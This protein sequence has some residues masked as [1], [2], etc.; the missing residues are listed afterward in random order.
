MGSPSVWGGELMSDR[1]GFMLYFDIE[2]ALTM[3]KDSQRGQLFTAIMNYA[4]YADVP[5]FEDKLIGMAWSLIRPSLDR[6]RRSYEKKVFDNRIKGLKSDFRRNYAPKHGIDPDDEVEME[7]Y[8]CQRMSTEVDIRQRTE[9]PILA[10]IEAI[11]LSPKTTGEGTRT[12]VQG[13]VENSTAYGYGAG[14]DFD[15]LRNQKMRQLADYAL[16]DV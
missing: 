3:L 16:N 2:P 15:N 1:P 5:D 6:D 12:G 13:E 10:Q 4:H 9:T 11:T 7:K 8:I 14:S